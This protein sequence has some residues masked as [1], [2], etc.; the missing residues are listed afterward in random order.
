MGWRNSRA[1]TCCYQCR[2]RFEA[3]H[4]V[5]SAYL[6]AKEKEK[7]ENERIKQEQAGDHLYDVYHYKQITRQKYKKY[8]NKAR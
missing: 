4:D 2:E 6:Q 1:G 3:C 8:K 5:C 7:A